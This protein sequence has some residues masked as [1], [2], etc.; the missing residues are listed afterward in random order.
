[1]SRI[2]LL[3]PEADAVGR[4]LQTAICGWTA[5]DVT[6]DPMRVTCKRCARTIEK[7]VFARDRVRITWDEAIADVL[8]VIAGPPVERYPEL[9][10]ELWASMRCARGQAH[11][12]CIFCR[13]D[14]D[15]CGA[16]AAWDHSQQIRPHR[17]YGHPFGSVNAALESLLR[18]QRDGAS[19]R[20]SAGS[21]QARAQET[22]RLGVEVQTT[23][24]AD[25]ED[26]TT[27]R[28][29]QAVDVER[30]VHRAYAQQSDRRGL[31]VGDCAA[32]L[33]DSVSPEAIP[34][35]RWAERFDVTP[36]A[37]RGIIK[38]GRKWVTVSLAAS[39]Y[40][41]EPHARVGLASEIERA[42]A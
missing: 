14:E 15:N 8:A 40:I 39:G 18:W 30:A 29:T 7:R 32:V 35:E 21:T 17:R 1:M 24:R 42:K 23:V 27:R 31:G 13:I 25:R 6:E 26:L 4:S 28:A 20:S 11:C 41:P 12:R 2:H 33:L 34:V 5:V 36:N 9:T 38:H 16:R 10:P 3:D 37:I 19:A 22:A